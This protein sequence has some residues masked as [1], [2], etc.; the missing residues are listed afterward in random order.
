[1]FHEVWNVGLIVNKSKRASDD[2]YERRKNKRTRRAL[3]EN[4]TK[5]LKELRVCLEVLMDVLRSLPQEASVFL[6]NDSKRTQTLSKYVQRFG[7]TPVE[8]EDQTVWVLTVLKKKEVL[9][10]YGHTN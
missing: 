10:R 8:Y 6:V 5:T 4:K 1:M 2:W 9:L 3:R 7:F